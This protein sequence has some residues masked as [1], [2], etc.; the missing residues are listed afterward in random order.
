MTLT[1]DH[2]LA[3]AFAGTFAFLPTQIPTLKNQK[4]L[5]LPTHDNI[6]DI[7][8]IGQCNFTIFDLLKIN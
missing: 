8:T 6:M 1:C 7:Y 5:P 3:N 4:S 2:N